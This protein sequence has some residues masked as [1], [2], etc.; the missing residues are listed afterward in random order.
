MVFDCFL[1]DSKDQ[2]QSKVFVSAGFLGTTEYWGEL[3]VAWS[4]C[5]KQHGLEYFKTSEYKMLRG[6]FEKFRS[7]PPPTGRGKASEVRD[8]L[9]AI[10]RKLSG[11]K[12]VGCVVP[13]ADY[14]KVCA[15]PEA[16]EFFEA[17][18]YRRA[19]E[20]LFND[21][22]R[23]LE[24]LPGKHVVA[25]VHD[26][27]D[28]FDELRRYYREYK[29]INTIHAKM[30]GGFQSLVDTLHPSL[31]MADAIANFTQE[32]AIE[33]LE[34]GRKTMTS[35]WPFNIY[36]LGIWNEKFMLSVL[37]HELKRRGKS[38]PEDLQSEK[39]DNN[40]GWSAWI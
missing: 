36:K 12:G 34:N 9:L 15:R 13:V 30:M 19:L 33:W 4:R 38:I 1:D 37:K 31:Q 21:V 25:Y 39:H 17:K 28:D 23:A 7:Y 8:S 5:L 10:P 6:Q 32:K 16:K 27:G 20:G 29:S 24:A 3:R 22:G 18:P 35:A 26:E 40:K 2:D 14:E 11:I